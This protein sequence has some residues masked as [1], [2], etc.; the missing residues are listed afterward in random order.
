MTADI[1]VRYSRGFHPLPRIS[2]GPALAVGIESDAEFVDLELVTW[3]PARVVAARLNSSLPEEIRVLNVLE[4]PLQLPALSASIKKVEYQIV[5]D[6]LP[7]SSPLSD[8]L[9]E[10]IDQRTSPCSVKINQES[11]H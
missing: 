3:L 9:P 5:M 6:D 4:I 1:G 11:R 8:S 7:D 10:K 2:F